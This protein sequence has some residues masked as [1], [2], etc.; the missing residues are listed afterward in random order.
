[1]KANESNYDRKIGNVLENL[2]LIDIKQKCKNIGIF[3]IEIKFNLFSHFLFM[4]HAFVI[5]KMPY[6]FYLDFH[7]S[8]QLNSFQLHGIFRA[9]LG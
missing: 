2:T 1:M 3:G 8:F 6:S 4:V 7:L 5:S 9:Y